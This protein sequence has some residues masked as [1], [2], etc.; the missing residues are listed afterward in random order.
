MRD[1]RDVIEGLRDDVEEDIVPADE[2]EG[3]S[4]SWSW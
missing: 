3:W 4:W 2:V 1:V